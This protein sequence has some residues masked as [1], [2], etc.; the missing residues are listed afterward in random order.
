MPTR[1]STPLRFPTTGHAMLASQLIPRA[2]SGERRL[3][4]AVL[5][6][7]LD[8]LRKYPADHPLHRRAV[9][10]I[11]DTHESCTGWPYRFQAVCEILDMDPVLVRRAVVTPD[12]PRG[13]PPP[14]APRAARDTP[15]AGTARRSTAPT[16]GAA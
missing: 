7:A 10:W 11:D 3:C 4:A 6:L 2:Q 16:A 13:A 5:E 9:A 14:P 8:D 1:L 15:P 12:R